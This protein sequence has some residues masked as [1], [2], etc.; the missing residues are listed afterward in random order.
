MKRYV[1][2][3]L[4]ILSVVAV[5]VVGLAPTAPAKVPTK[6]VHFKESVSQ[7]KKDCADHGGTFDG[8]ANGSAGTC[9][10]NNSATS[11]S[12]NVSD[13]N[14]N[15][16]T[17]VYRTVPPKKWKE[18]QSLIS[19]ILASDGYPNVS[20]GGARPPTPGGTVT[21]T[22]G[23][24]TTTATTKPKTGATT[25]TTRPATTTTSVIP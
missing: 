13:S 19:F 14:G 4:I 18:F 2:G 23:S 7:L 12:D 20:S 9:F 5:L 21:T 17:K 6:E 15:N 3:T 22:G 8:S 1:V 16:C 10:R 24:T 11:C 25:T